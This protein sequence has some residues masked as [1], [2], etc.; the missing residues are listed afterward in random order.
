MAE[1]VEPQARRYNKFI[2]DNS[3]KE[4]GASN[5]ATG[6]TLQQSRV[7]GVERAGD[8]RRGVALSLWLKAI[9]TG[10][11]SAGRWQRACW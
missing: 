8:V 7:A 11:T 10:K 5:P 9:A 2:A 1:S 3:F 4:F 6:R